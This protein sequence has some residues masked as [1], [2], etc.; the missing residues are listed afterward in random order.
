MSV[1]VYTY[2]VFVTGQCTRWS[3]NEPNFFTHI[4]LIILNVQEKQWF[5]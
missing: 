3:K 1:A 5:Y 2:Y 4:V